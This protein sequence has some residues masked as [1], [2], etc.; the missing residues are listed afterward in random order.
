MLFFLKAFVRD[1]GKT[2]GFSE[3]IVTYDIKIDLCNQSNELL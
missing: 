2:M 1:K 3:A